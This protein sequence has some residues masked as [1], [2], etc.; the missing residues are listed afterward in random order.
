MIICIDVFYKQDSANA[1]AVL[2]EQWS[3]IKSFKEYILNITEVAEYVS[4]EFYKRELPCIMQLLA[5]IKEKDNLKIDLIVIDGYVWLSEGRK[6]LGAH[7]YEALNKEIP[8]IGVA[9]TYFHQNNAVEVYRGKS[10]NPLYISA[11]GIEIDVIAK[12]IERMSGEYRIPTIL[13][14]VDSLSREAK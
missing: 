12:S 6:G 4:G 3:D 9:K 8:V 2:I 5:H 7:L 1:A 14:R 13:K 10:Q 11:I